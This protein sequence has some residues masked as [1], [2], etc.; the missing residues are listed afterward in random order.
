MCLALAAESTS[1]G[2]Y[3]LDT[4]SALIAPNIIPANVMA[5]N[6]GNEQNSTHGQRLDVGRTPSTIYKYSSS[7]EL[8]ELAS[9][10]VRDP[11]FRKLGLWLHN[12]NTEL[13][14]C[15]RCPEG[16]LWAS[17]LTRMRRPPPPTTAA[18]TT[19]ARTAC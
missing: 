18:N 19:S 8:C 1:I 7:V 17:H 12:L 5:N 9:G 13:L 3:L 16:C 2:G 10:Y 11:S 15:H 14:R 4:A 6:V